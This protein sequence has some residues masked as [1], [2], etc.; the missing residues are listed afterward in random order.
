MARISRVME[1]RLL[2]IN[3]PPIKM[4][5]RTYY[6]LVPWCNELLATFHWYRH[7]SDCEYVYVKRSPPSFTKI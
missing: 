6:G 7:L 1:E 4:A 3:P 5:Y 2:A